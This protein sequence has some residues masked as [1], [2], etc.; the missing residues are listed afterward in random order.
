MSLSRVPPPDPK[1]GR[2]PFSFG[3]LKENNDKP[4]GDASESQVL[5][6]ISSLSMKS[7]LNLPGLS[8]QIG[9]GKDSR[10]CVMTSEFDFR[11]LVVSSF[12][13][14]ATWLVGFISL[15]RQGW[16]LCP[17][18]G[19]TEYPQHWTARKFLVSFLRNGFSRQS[20]QGKKLY[21][22]QSVFY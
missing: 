11:L 9:K 12:F 17:C 19:S 5:S 21:I 6:E 14:P 7:P 16:N 15:T 4:K 2:G 3:K 1:F 8:E 13:G 18:S 20:L 22:I 10:D